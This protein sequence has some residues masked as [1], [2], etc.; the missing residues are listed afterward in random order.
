MD[1]EVEVDSGVVAAAAASRRDIVIRVTTYNE[2]LK[3]RLEDGH[4]A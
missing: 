1:S 3:K 4:A 2:E